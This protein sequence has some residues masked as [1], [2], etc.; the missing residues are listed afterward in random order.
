MLKRLLCGGFITCRRAV[1]CLRSSP[2]QFCPATDTITSPDRTMPDCCAQPPLIVL[3]R[4]LPSLFDALYVKPSATLGAPAEEEEEELT[5]L[6]ATLATLP[7]DSLDPSFS[8]GAALVIAT[9]SLCPL[10]FLSTSTLAM[11]RGGPIMARVRALASS[12]PRGPS[13]SMVTTMSPGQMPE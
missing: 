10:F 9:I 7:I 12:L 2:V 5:S 1:T 11:E 8:D 3:A 6:A 13:P 4:H